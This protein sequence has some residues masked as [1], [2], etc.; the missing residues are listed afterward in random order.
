MHSYQHSR[1]RILFEVACAFGISASCLW[2]WQQTY[3]TAMV[4]AAAIAALYGLV[5]A[6][7]M[8]RRRPPVVESVAALQPAASQ[9][10]SVHFESSEAA[11][12]ELVPAF[13][14][15]V[16][17]VLDE[18]APKRKRKASRKAETLLDNPESEP[19]IVP[20]DP[21]P[22][23]EAAAVADVTEPVVEAVDVT[24]PEPEPEPQLH[25]VDTAPEAP[26]YYPATPLFE[27]EPFVRQQRAAF[28]RKAR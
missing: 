11:P 7:D 12:M 6:F 25:V 24:A 19:Q 18:P 5:H 27:T 8:F 2:A 22:E 26:E 13:V 10:A 4:P 20:A 23:P 16:Q 1:G 17:Q 3:A 9:D 28:G 21:D 15:P 14:E